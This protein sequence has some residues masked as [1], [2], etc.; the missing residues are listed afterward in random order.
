MSPTAVRRTVLVTRP[1]EAAAE[2]AAIVAALGFDVVRAPALRRVRLDRLTRGD[3]A[4]AQAAVVTSAAGVAAL[5]EDLP[6]DLFPPRCFAVGQA[7]AAAARRAGMRE[8]SVGGGDA[9]SL[10][11]ILKA[12]DPATGVV[13]FL[14]GREVAR[15]LAPSLEAAGFAVRVK[16]VYGADRAPALAPE[17]VAALRAERVAAALFLSRRTV[18]A[19]VA[20]AAAA[21]VTERLRR[22]A[23]VCNSAQTAEGGGDDAAFARILI[24]REPTLASAVEVL[25]A[26]LRP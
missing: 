24:A 26:T 20:L 5:A 8:V 11:P 17:A 2:T 7:T 19:F 22:V 25:G 12:L 3:V 18:E 10:L 4:D 13:L 21:G 1:A 6:P 15:P 23:A 14:L 9:E 16:T